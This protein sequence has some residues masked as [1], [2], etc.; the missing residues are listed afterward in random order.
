MTVTWHVDDIKVS[1]KEPF[2]I[3]KFAHCLSL[4]YDKKLAAKRGK[5][6]DYLHMDLKY[7]T[8]G[9]V[10][11]SIMNYLKNVEDEFPIEIIGTA[12]SPACEHLF[13]ADEDDDKQKHYLDTTRAIQCH[14]VTAQLLFASRRAHQDIQTTL[15]FL[16]SHFKKPDEDDWGKLVRCMKYLKGTKYMKLNLTVDN[17]SVIKWWMDASHNTH[18]DRQ[19]HTGAMMNLG[20]GASINHYGKHKLNT[21]SYT[22]S[23]LVGADDMLVKVLWVLYF[24][25][26]QGYTVDQNIMYQN[27][28]TTIRSACAM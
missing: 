20:K 24:I 9:A 23:E 3:T 18:M 1:Q 26:A 22:E 25:Q 11:V 14:R 28:M 4:Q 8:K 7:S 16:T 27:S 19:G 5:V 12:K 13:Q 2:E 21:K 6:N 10:K 17:M 15:S